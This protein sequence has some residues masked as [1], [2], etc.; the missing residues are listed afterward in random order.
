MIIRIASTDEEIQKCF[1]AI[2][3]LRPFLKEDEFVSR[4]RRLM[5]DGFI[6]AYV[7]MEDGSV[8]AASGFRIEEMLHR[9]KSI[10]IDELS[11]LESARSKGL[12]GMLIDYIIDLAKKEDC[13]SVHLDSG[14]QRFAAHRF[15][16]KK[17]FDIVSHHFALHLKSIE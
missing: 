7:E 3:A 12:G 1:P 6:L 4:I 16:L 5:K 14:V 13:A 11:T 10:Y 15:Y 8:P 9:G 2:H 17:K